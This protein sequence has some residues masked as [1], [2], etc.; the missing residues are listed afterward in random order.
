M[1][2]MVAKSTIFL[3][4]SQEWNNNGTP[5]IFDKMPASGGL[6]EFTSD[7]LYSIPVE[8]SEK[9]NSDRRE[10][11]PPVRDN[12]KLSTDGVDPFY[13]DSGEKTQMQFFFHCSF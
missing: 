8:E 1:T 5:L 12:I 6:G 13:I 7:H 3:E 9:F 10:C 4:D 11:S 2:I